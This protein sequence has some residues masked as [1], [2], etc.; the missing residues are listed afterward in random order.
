VF[1]LTS[2][3]IPNTR[4]VQ[5]AGMAIAF[6]FAVEFSQL[7]HASWIDAIRSTTMGGLVPGF[8]FVWTDLICYAVGVLFGASAGGLIEARYAA[9]E[10]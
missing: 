6:S 9:Q 10:G 3:A 4:I 5:R 8:D 2:A 7:Y 1:L